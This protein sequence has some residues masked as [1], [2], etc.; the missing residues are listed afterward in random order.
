MNLICDAR[1]YLAER[2]L[3]KGHAE[4]ICRSVRLFGEFLER[5]ARRA[6]LVERRVNRWLADVATRR[7]SATVMGHRRAITAVWNWLAEQSL[8]KPYD[9]RRLRKVKVVTPTPKPWSM[10]QV[11][12][13][14]VAA[15]EMRQVLPNGLIAGE[16]LSAIVL[17]SYSTGLRVSDILDL[18]ND[19]LVDGRLSV[20]QSK[21][22]QP[23]TIELGNDAAAALNRISTA[24]GERLIPISRRQL[25]YWTDRLFHFATRYGFDRMPGQGIGT[26]RKTGATEVARHYGLEQAARFLG[27]IGGVEIA[28]KHY[29]APEAL[30]SP[31][32]PP[33]IKHGRSIRKRRHY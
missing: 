17:C 26:L 29:V 19:D 22:G 16:V 12:I 30:G 5:P 20:I 32:Q 14:L 4:N 27:H 11:K 6:D 10:K 7:S 8:V 21:T 25:R 24:A 28:R 13:L 15:G 3:S 1:D 33:R 9:V 23:H 2:D 31:P 18:R